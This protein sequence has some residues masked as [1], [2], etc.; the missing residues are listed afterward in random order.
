MNDNFE[1][2]GDH[3]ADPADSQP[4]WVTGVY[5]ALAGALSA[6]VWGGLVWVAVSALADRA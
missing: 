4:D 6:S 1:M 5:F 3:G 2:T